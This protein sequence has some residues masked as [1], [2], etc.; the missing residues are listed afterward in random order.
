[1]ARFVTEGAYDVASGELLVGEQPKTYVATDNIKA[2]SYV[3]IKASDLVAELEHR[4][5]AF[6]RDSR[7]GVTLHLLG[8]LEP[9]GKVG[10][11]CIAD[12]DKEADVLYEGVI[13]TLDDLAGR[14]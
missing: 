13:A 6:D 11:I 12:G 8:A 3:G 10:A 14:A 1:M 7:T 2:T 9:F 5:L 4:E